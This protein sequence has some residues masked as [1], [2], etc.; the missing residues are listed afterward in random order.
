V[1]GLILN[2]EKR[3]MVAEKLG[4]KKI[5]ADVFFSVDLLRESPDEQVIFNQRPIPVP[6]GI[7][8]Q[9]SQQQRQRMRNFCRHL[10]QLIQSSSYDMLRN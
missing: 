6:R 9:M 8:P 7:H 10:K 2:G 3:A 5:D 4:W 1:T